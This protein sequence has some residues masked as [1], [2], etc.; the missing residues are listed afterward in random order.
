ML[1]TPCC[2]VE[3]RERLAGTRHARDEAYG[4]LIGGLRLLDDLFER[5]R[6]RRQISGA[7][8]GARDLLN[9]MLLKQSLRSFDDGGRWPIAR[10]KPGNRINGEAALISL[11]A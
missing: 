1:R 2:D 11:K 8:I 5:V 7:R 3:P 10:G 9:L 6:R 4:L